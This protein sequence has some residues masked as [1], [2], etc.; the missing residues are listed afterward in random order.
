MRCVI[1]ENIRH[2]GERVRE[3]ASG[4]RREIE[5]RRQPKWTKRRSDGQ[6]TSN[7]YFNFCVLS[8]QQHT[9]I[10]GETQARAY[11]LYSTQQKFISILPALILCS[12]SEGKK[13]PDPGFDRPIFMAY[14]QRVFD[15]FFVLMVRLYETGRNGMNDVEGLYIVLCFF[16]HISSPTQHTKFCFVSRGAEL[17][18]NSTFQLERRTKRAG[19]SRRKC[20][21]MEWNGLKR[22]EKREGKIIAAI[23]LENLYWKHTAFYFSFFFFPFEIFIFLR[24]VRFKRRFLR[25]EWNT[26]R[27]LGKKR[28]CSPLIKYKIICALMVVVR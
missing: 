7:H 20:H 9:F 28:R 23:I 1:S 10:T 12:P 26:R 16:I 11:S 6:K 19:R 2:R 3:R 18:G 4:W 14:T 5:A 22:K 27:R 25:F 21:G 24:Y 8:Q 15:R 17:K 13:T